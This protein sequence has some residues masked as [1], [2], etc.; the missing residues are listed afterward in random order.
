MK[1]NSYV[2]GSL[3]YLSTGIS[4]T[5]NSMNT[6]VWRQLHVQMLRKLRGGKFQTFE[7]DWLRNTPTE[8]LLSKALWLW[9]K[10]W[11]QRH[12]RLWSFQIQAVRLQKALDAR[13]LLCAACLLNSVSASVS[14]VKYHSKAVVQRTEL[15]TKRA[16]WKEPKATDSW[17]SGL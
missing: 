16:N 7:I 3:Q 11:L 1:E 17:P 15:Y 8:L 14:S 9:A 2:F 12:S 6:Q 4:L 5:R 10:Q 13:P